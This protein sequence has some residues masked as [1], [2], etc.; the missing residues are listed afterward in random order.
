MS[1]QQLTTDE[2][3]KVVRLLISNRSD[4]A[5]GYFIVMVDIANGTIWDI[6]NCESCHRAAEL[7]IQQ[8]ESELPLERGVRL[9][10]VY[11]ICESQDCR[12]GGAQVRF[13]PFVAEGR[14]VRS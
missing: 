8:F 11:G 7:A 14:A 13:Y 9:L 3:A 2:K 5:L 12:C 1:F 6:F 10:E 4:W